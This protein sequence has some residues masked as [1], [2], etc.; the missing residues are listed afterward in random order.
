MLALH[1]NLH[2]IY[3][4]DF[5]TENA[6]ITSQPSDRAV[7][8]GDDIELSVTV[9]GSVAGYQWFGPGGVAL[10]DGSRI[11]D[12]TTQGVLIFSA[13]LSDAG[14]Y[15]VRVTGLGAGVTVDSDTATVAIYC[16]FQILF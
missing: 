10:V 9:S 2:N 5:S 11:A 3:R 7:L 12:S 4:C 14:E 15:F 13:V 1:V 8:V 16:E 6:A